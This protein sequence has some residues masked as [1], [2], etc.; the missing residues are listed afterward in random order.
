MGKVAMTYRLMPESTDFD[1]GGLDRT[2]ASK[3][4][5]GSE[6]REGRVVPIAF[7]LSSFEVMIVAEDREGISDGV[8]KAL[9]GISGIQS[10]DSVEIT[11]L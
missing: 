11:L 4:P 5:E 6:L 9:A 8:E 2:I 1:F 7:G 10:V 3:L